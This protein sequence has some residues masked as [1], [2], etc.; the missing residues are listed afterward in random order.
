MIHLLVLFVLSKPCKATPI[1]AEEAKALV[2]EVP[3]ARA[4]IKER[5]AT[6]DAEI[7]MPL[8]DGWFFRVY[9]TNSTSPSNLIGYYV[10]NNRTAAVTDESGEPPNKPVTSKRLKTRQKALLRKHC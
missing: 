1:S 5:G 3:N 7:E 8:P 9:A 6:L 2:L 4:S 10:V